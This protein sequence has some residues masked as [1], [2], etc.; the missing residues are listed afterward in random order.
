MSQPLVINGHHQELV[1]ENQPWLGCPTMT[2]GNYCQRT[3][4]ALCV[5]TLLMLFHWL[6][7]VKLTLNFVK[8]MKHG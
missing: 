2:L 6:S 7:D 3:K 4:Y 5:A 8:D 1:M